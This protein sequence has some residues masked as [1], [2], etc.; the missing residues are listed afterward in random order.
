MNKKLLLPFIFLMLS[1]NL[2]ANPFISPGSKTNAASAAGDPSVGQTD[3]SAA[4]KTEAAPYVRISAGSDANL[5]NRGAYMKHLEAFYSWKELNGS[6]NSDKRASSVLWVI[7]SASFVFGIVHALGPAVKP[8]FF[9]LHIAPLLVDRLQ[10]GQRLSPACRK[11]HCHYLFRKVLPVQFHKSRCHCKMDGRVFVSFTHNHSSHSYYSQHYRFF[12][13]S[14][15]IERR[16][17]LQEKNHF[18]WSLYCFGHLP[19]PRCSLSTRSLF[20]TQYHSAR[21]SFCSKHVARHEHSHNRKRLFCMGRARRL[22]LLFQ[23]KTKRNRAHI[24]HC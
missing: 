16:K 11:R 12:K 21:N 4:E 17:K 3:N 15:R 8:W 2:F 22:I 14:Q 6:E 23:I 5:K 13:A 10:Q 18:A 19:M 7:L 24:L 20:Y 9:A 1:I